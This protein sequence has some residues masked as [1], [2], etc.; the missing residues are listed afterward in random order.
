MQFEQGPA[1]SQAEFDELNGKI[2]NL[3]VEVSTSAPIAAGSS[4]TIAYPTG[5]TMA[6]TRVVYSMLYIGSNVD[7]YPTA[8]EVQTISSDGIHAKNVG[9]ASGQIVI[10]IVK[11]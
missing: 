7:R 4:A 5:F 1:P 8:V 6:N 11:M 9:G 10:G 2:E 3:I